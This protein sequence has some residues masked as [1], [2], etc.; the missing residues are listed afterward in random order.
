MAT[1]FVDLFEEFLIREVDSAKILSY[2]VDFRYNLLSS[3]LYGGREMYRDIIYS[4]DGLALNKAEDCIEFQRQTYNYT[5]TNTTFVQVLSPI[6]PTNA[7]FYV[8]VNNVASQN[9]SYD[10]LTYT[11]TI[12]GLTGT[13]NIYIGAY[14]NG[15]FNQTLNL[16]ERGLFVRLMGLQWLRDKIKTDKLICQKVYGKDWGMH[17]QAN[18]LKELDDLYK[19]E[20]DSVYKDIM[21]YSYRNSPHDLQ[22]L[23]GAFN[24]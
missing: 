1:P 22:E 21:L 9:F 15:Q 6:P 2:K 23:G 13:S 16:T 18:H 17:S 7:S 8:E 19:Y 3:L 4:N 12:T 5:T 20:Y 11:I 10:P 14:L 24:G